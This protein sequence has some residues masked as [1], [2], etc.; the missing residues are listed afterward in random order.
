MT[1]LRELQAD[2]ELNEVWASAHDELADSEN[3]TTTSWLQ[4]HPEDK[5]TAIEDD[6][7]YFIHRVTGA[8]FDI[9]DCQAGVWEVD[10]PEFLATSIHCNLQ[11]ALDAGEEKPTELQQIDL[12]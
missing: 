10:H 5:E 4:Q 9:F 2:P 12:G 6:E 3:W 11:D 8:T 7:Q 1:T